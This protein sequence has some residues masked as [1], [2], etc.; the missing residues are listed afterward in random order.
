MFYHLKAR[1]LPHRANVVKWCYAS[2]W[3]IFGYQLK[4]FLMYTV[5]SV[6]WMSSWLF[7]WIC[8][9]KETVYENIQCTEVTSCTEY[10]WTL[11]RILNFLRCLLRWGLYFH[12]KFLQLQVILD[13]SRSWYLG[14]SI[15]LRIWW[16]TVALNCGVKQCITFIEILLSCYVYQCCAKVCGSFYIWFF[17]QW[18]PKNHKTELFYSGRN[19]NWW[20][21]AT[22]RN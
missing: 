11:Q 7:Y 10:P 13:N 16:N 8:S 17:V 22:S 18:C 9:D 3:N 6:Y 2:R 12:N 21:K 15:A 20:G 14:L 1:N 19:D 5:V 4:I